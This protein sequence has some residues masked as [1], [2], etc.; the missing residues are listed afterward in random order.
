MNIL[1]SNSKT[2]FLA[3]EP[4]KISVEFTTALAIKKGQPIKLTAAGLATP[5]AP[6]DLLHTLVGYA[7]SD[8]AVGELLT[9]WT[10]GYCIIYALSNAALSAGPVA[11]TSYDASTVVGGVSGYSKYATNATPA[12]NNAWS[13]NQATAADELIMVLLMD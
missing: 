12:Q 11:Y 9:V 3:S 1:G 7:Y 2:T 4:E 10:R 6:A 5:W 8:C 13:L